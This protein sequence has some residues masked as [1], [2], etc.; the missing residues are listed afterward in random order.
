M[1]VSEAS[2]AAATLGSPHPNEAWIEPIP[3]GLITSPGADPGDV[4]A[5]RESV[6]LAFVAALQLMRRFM[7]RPP[8]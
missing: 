8:C 7:I 5:T 4:A 1:D 6:R 3:D 2:W